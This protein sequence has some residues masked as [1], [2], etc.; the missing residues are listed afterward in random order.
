MSVHELRNRIGL[1]MLIAPMCCGFIIGLVRELIEK[2]MF[3]STT[4]RP[5]N[6]Q[7]NKQN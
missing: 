1:G 4:D 7:T 3:N 6:K 5:T 2:G